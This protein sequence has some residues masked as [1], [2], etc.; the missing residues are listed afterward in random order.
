[1]HNAPGVQ[2][3]VSWIPAC[4]SGCS[5]Q[6]IDNDG[7]ALNATWGWAHELGH[8]TV[9]N[10]MHIVM[11]NG[12][13]CTVECDNNTLSSTNMMRLYA[14][15]GNDFSA[16]NTGFPAL[17]KMIQDNRAAYPAG[18]EAM[19]ADMATRLWEGDQNPMRAMYF[20]LA[21]LYTQVRQHQ[22]LPTSESTIDFM[23]L[24]SKGGRLVA[25]TKDATQWSADRA[26]YGMGSYTNNTIENRDLL[27]VLGSK[28]IGQDLRN[29]FFM[30][31]I[32]LTQTSL[33]SVA[34]LNLCVAQQKYYQLAADKSNQPTTGSWG[35][36][37]SAQTPVVLN[38]CS[39]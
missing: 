7:W 33:D 20:Q 18:G 3:F 38:K 22:A 16:T 14:L 25:N 9:Q 30:Y 26:K 37:E 24:L 12:K 28:I 10:W 27:Y 21:F 8:N 35:S 15:T 5:G 23:T 39:S 32:P 34:S 29:V 6:P 4:G 19:R 1:M 36:L 11:P 13:G 17:Y 31:G 2:H